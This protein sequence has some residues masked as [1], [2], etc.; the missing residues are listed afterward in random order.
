M[1]FARAAAIRPATLGR[2]F[3]EIARDP[4]VAEALFEILETQKILEQ[5]GRLVLLPGGASGRM[6]GNLLASEPEPVA[7]PSKKVRVAEV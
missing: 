4:A 7:G 5:K 6:L 3:E 1:E 2:A